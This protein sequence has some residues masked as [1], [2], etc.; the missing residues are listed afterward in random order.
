M[1]AVASLSGRP[2]RTAPESGARAAYLLAR[3]IAAHPPLDELLRVAV[4]ASRELFDA[5]EAA[6]LLSDEGAATRALAGKR[7]ISAAPP[8]SRP[9][10]RGDARV[11]YC[12]PL[13]IGGESLGLIRLTNPGA[14][15][16]F[17]DSDLLLLNRI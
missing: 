8:G 15:H 5:E 17:A 9:A 12:A 4:A 11:V 6:L 1:T 10:V 13:A 16:A 2:A 3:T 7:V 14:G